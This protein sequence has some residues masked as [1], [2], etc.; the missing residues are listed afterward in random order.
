M[1]Q[2]HWSIF[3]GLFLVGSFHVPSALA[4]DEHKNRTHSPAS[5]RAATVQHPTVQARTQTAAPRVQHQPA[6]QLPN[7]GRGSAAPKIVPAQPARQVHQPNEAP[8]IQLTREPAPRHQA[9]QPKLIQQIPS[10]PKANVQPQ[11]DG[12]TNVREL[13]RLNVNPNQV[14]GGNPRSQPVAGPQAVQLPVNQPQNPPNLQL[15]QRPQLPANPPQSNGRTSVQPRV[16]QP[17]KNQRDTP[18]RGGGLPAVDPSR[19]PRLNPGAVNPKSGQP[20]NPGLDRGQ[21]NTGTQ[22]KVILPGQLDR[23]RDKPQT[24]GGLPVPDSSRLP[25]FKPNPNPVD[26][27]VDTHRNPT[28]NLDR[29]RGNSNG[30]NPSLVIPGTGNPQ[31]PGNAAA[32]VRE[33]LPMRID[34]PIVGEHRK[35]IPLTIPKNGGGRPNSQTLPGDR[36][37]DQLQALLKS[38]DHQDLK[39][40]LDQLRHSPDFA[41]HPQLSHLNLDRISGL[42]QDRLRNDNAFNNWRQA[43]VGQQLNL[44]RQFQL[45]R[46]GDLTRQMNFSANVINAGGWQHRHHGAVAASFTSTSF[47]VWYA[48]GGCYPRHCWYPRWSPWVNWCWW[49]SCVPFYDPR[50]IYCR[51]IVYQPCQPW[52]VQPYPVWQPLPVVTCGTWVDVQ[53]IVLPA[54]LDLQLL[55]VRFVDNGHPEQN[56]GPRYR[57]WLRNNS[58]VQITSP[59]SVLAL[60]DNDLAPN[61]GVPQAGVVIPTMDIGEIRPVDIRLPLEANR[62]GVT[63]EGNHVPFAYLHVLVD[64]HQQTVE[65]DETNNGSVVARTDILPVDPAAFS[66]D[67]T[68]AAPGGTLTIAGEGFGPEPGRV[69]VSVNGQNTEALILGWYDLGV[70]FTVP[71]YS[72]TGTVDAEVLVVRGDGAVS[73][74]LDIQLAPESLLGPTVEIPLAP[75]PVPPQ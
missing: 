24:G 71:G 5:S 25:Q 66:T 69:L 57:V 40:N 20:S 58:P 13:P 73:N 65:T 22:P 3:A 39:N 42:H 61:T 50:P 43:N 36:D 54:G 62:L 10:Q 2:S 53:P 41:K 68:A 1:A 11:N 51:P 9:V 26:P 8:R 18:Q 21:G 12:R 60:A 70:R 45:Q 14:T 15:R 19:P 29:G 6:A 16:V 4:K 33:H 32:K 7:S 67:Q 75:L 64:S 47:S 34:H 35:A 48:G 37:R 38:R 23:Q 59:F 44:D 56:L 49:D 63:P 55:A 52:I 72:L 27:K 28:L 31:T 17:E 74:P 46:R 30:R